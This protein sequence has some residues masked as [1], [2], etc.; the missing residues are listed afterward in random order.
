MNLLS[1]WKPVL[2]RLSEALILMVALLAAWVLWLWYADD[3][4]FEAVYVA[5]GALLAG[6]LVARRWLKQRP[7]TLAAKA[8]LLAKEF[9]PHLRERLLD[10]VETIWI[11]GV[12]Q[13][14]IHSEVLKLTMSYRP[15][16]VGQRAW[17]LV[18]KQKGEANQTL[19]PERTLLDLFNRSGRNLL[20]LAQ[21]GNGKT[22]TILQLAEALIEE[23]RRNPTAPMTLILNLSS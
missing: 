20:I 11:E 3:G 1:K 21:P 16:A 14:S 23:A 12:L 6:L 18:L 10:R 9:S 7:E 13:Q 19:P 8:D 4:G 22:A 17:Q 2:I 15:D 5:I